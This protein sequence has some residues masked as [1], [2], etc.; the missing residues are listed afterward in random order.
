METSAKEYL[1]GFGIDTKRII[2]RYAVLIKTIHEF[3][4]HYNLKD[5]VIINGRVLE[6]VIIDYFVDSVRV[7]E[8]HNI[9][10]TNTEKVYAYATYWLVRR[11]PIQ[12]KENFNGCEFINEYFVTTFLASNIAIEK[13]INVTKINKSPA[14]L[15]FQELLFYNL[16]YRVLTQQ[17]LELM[18][19][20]FFC[21]C[22]VLNNE[23]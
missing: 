3:I 21:G 15:Q 14:F 16:K 4:K 7:K 5:K 18:I 12:I 17:S 1:K 11:K 19:E 2:N 9:K 13:G 20:A 10:N 8:F 22:D 23:A 6:Q